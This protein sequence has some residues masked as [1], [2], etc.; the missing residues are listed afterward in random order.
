[1]AAPFGAM[2]SLPDRFERGGAGGIGRAWRFRGP[3]E[4]SVW[5]AGAIPWPGFLGGPDNLAPAAPAG[6]LAPPA[7]LF[8]ERNLL[9]GR[10]AQI[11]ELRRRLAPRGFGTAPF[12]VEAADVPITPPRSGRPYT[13]R[14]RFAALRAAGV[15]PHALGPEQDGFVAAA[16]VNAV[17]RRIVPTGSRPTATDGA[18]FGVD[19]DEEAARPDWILPE[20]AFAPS[21]ALGVVEGDWPRD[22]PQSLQGIE[23]VATSGRPFQEASKEGAG[24]V[25]NIAADVKAMGVGRCRRVRQSDIYYGCTFPVREVEGDFFNFGTAVLP[26]GELRQDLEVASDTGVARGRFTAAQVLL[27]TLAGLAGLGGVKVALTPLCAG[28]GMALS[29]VDSA[30]GSGNTATIPLYTDPTGDVSSG[31]AWT[32]VAAGKPPWQK[33]LLALSGYGWNR[34]YWHHGIGRQVGTAE[35]LYQQYALNVW[36]TVEGEDGGIRSAYSRE[37]ARRKGLAVAA[38]ADAV[39]EWLQAVQGVWRWDGLEL[40]D[41]VDY[42]ELGNEMDGFWETGTPAA[43]AFGAGAG[44]ASHVAEGAM[45][46]GRYMALL[47]APIR[48]RLPH[49]KFRT[50][51]HS[52]GYLGQ[53]ETGALPPDSF[54]Y[55]VD[56]LRQSVAPGLTTEVGRWAALQGEGWIRDVAAAF[57]IVPAASWFTTQGSEWWA[58]C[59]AARFRWPP[60]WDVPGF[61]SADVQVA[62]REGTVSAELQLLMASA[63]ASS[64]PLPRATDLIH[65]VGF[66][67]YHNTD[68]TRASVS[69][70]LGYVDSER[71]AADVATLRTEVVDRLGRE[72]GF[73]LGITVGEIGFPAHAPITPPAGSWDIAYYGFTTP[74]FQAAML[75]RYALT[76]LASGVESASMYAFFYGGPDSQ[77]AYPAY[78]A[79]TW[80]NQFNTQGLHNDVHFPNAPP[81]SPADTFQMVECFPRPAW[82]TL[83]RLAWLLRGGNRR[84]PPIRPELLH[85]G[86]GLTLIRLSFPD[87]L[88]VGPDGVALRQR[89]RYA[90]I[91]WND[92]YATSAAFHPDPAERGPGTVL[93]AFRDPFDSR[94]ELLSLVPDIEDPWAA[95]AAQDG[96]GYALPDPS[97]NPVWRWSGWD[98]AIERVSLSMF[99]GYFLLFLKQ[100]AP[101]ASPPVI[102]PVCFLTNAEPW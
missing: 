39:G 66:H 81:R 72:A 74:R 61:V 62:I 33:G 20:E 6:N 94:Y 15:A 53:A 12:W 17:H 91:A 84:A 31:V 63:A 49:M 8:D 10:N 26:P 29:W 21:E 51:L 71:L 98:A 75:L 83:R 95:G 77:V 28:G 38:Y 34:F 70:R 64:R 82:F 67:F 47:A 13:L 16:I 50:E 85:N 1:M 42:L 24:T 18:A 43:E 27:E 4:P 36:P 44:A 80:G 41:V 96:N 76:C 89:W 14:K 73:T 58:S 55:Q 86:S 7:F 99:E 92:Q 56:W 11:A 59:T 68:R 101:G 46:F 9:R 90:Y 78:Q 88:A 93:L 22:N 48:Y 97:R 54:P 57:G 23:D 25:G 69:T 35:T 32:D 45:E 100:I 79:G 37:C 52:W 2:G 65:Q 5:L 60:A 19:A 40:Y 3:G 102:A 30:L 87:G